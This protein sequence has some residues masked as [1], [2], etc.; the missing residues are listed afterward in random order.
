MQANLLLGL[1]GKD[2][3]APKG[4]QIEQAKTDVSLFETVL[5]ELTAK[6]EISPEKQSGFAEAAAIVGSNPGN[7]TGEIEPESVPKPSLPS[8][9][10]PS[11]EVQSNEKLAETVDKPQIL[12]SVTH[13]GDAK[14]NIPDIQT[15][16]PAILPIA[17]NAQ[18]IQHLPSHQESNDL[19]STS[20]NEIG[21]ELALPLSK[22]FVGEN[23]II[24]ANI[25]LPTQDKIA[26]ELP[27]LATK[28][29]MPETIVSAAS[30]KNLPILKAPVEPIAQVTLN[31]PIEAKI[32]K[33]I[34]HQQ[35]EAGEQ[36]SA[37][38]VS[39]NPLPESTPSLVEPGKTIEQKVTAKEVSGFQNPV[40]RQD[41]V[42]N[43]LKELAVSP[44]PKPVAPEK[45]QAAPQHETAP[46]LA[47]SNSKTVQLEIQHKSV[48]EVIAKPQVPDKPIA[49]VFESSRQTARIEPEHANNQPRQKPTEQVPG[50]P[51][52]DKAASPPSIP[53]VDTA[54]PTAAEPLAFAKADASSPTQTR[55][56][57]AS[58]VRVSK[59][60]SPEPFASKPKP[61]EGV[62]VKS[63]RLSNEPELARTS[64]KILV[65]PDKAHSQIAAASNTAP[66]TARPEIISVPE[67]WPRH[68]PKHN[69]TPKSDSDYKSTKSV[70]NVSTPATSTLSGLMQTVSKPEGLSG[71]E[72]F[73]KEF[74]LEPLQ[75]NGSES[76]LKDSPRIFNS[77]NLPRHVAMQIVEVAR[78][79]P[80]RPVEISLNP[81][82]L[83]RVRISLGTIEG[84]IQVSLTAERQETLELIRR[85]IE[86]LA[87]EFR[88]MGFADISFDFG[89]P[90]RQNE[91]SRESESI[92]DVDPN[93]RNPE[94]AKTQLRLEL[95]SSLDIRM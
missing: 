80:D 84:A 27:E 59:S 1:L 50:W 22:N 18:E 82:E 72:F 6:I 68:Q 7:D 42:S 63:T 66:V 14:I 26:R 73:G 44:T 43:P 20:I 12:P 10:P 61:V 79:L 49:P 58:E 52:A 21:E 54:K 93:S 60:Y 89:D 13:S 69:T 57:T 4:M 67:S 71:R 3:V 53:I 41:P 28:Q 11:I 24:Q 23:R 8:T 78:T 46:I 40:L 86:Q 37:K 95:G 15:A 87:E 39:K 74:S 19:G 64:E 77:P 33:E 35:V 29:Q 30:D 38:Q 45:N 31:S 94:E 92:S 85:N 91:N 5:D 70:V 32:A 88:D 17:H 90:E 34:P 47:S 83:G 65:K 36:V 48:A 81:E 16:K 51:I 62:Q 9:E 76:L 2:V 55:D 75:L 25:E 56:M